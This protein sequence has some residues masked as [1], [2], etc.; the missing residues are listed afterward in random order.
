MRRL[1]PLPVLFAALSL[2]LAACQTDS[3]TVTKPAVKARSV[4]HET[5]LGRDGVR[6]TIPG[7]Y[8]GRFEENQYFDRVFSCEEH[9]VSLMYCVN[10]GELVPDEQSMAYAV[11]RNFELEYPSSDILRQPQTTENGLTWDHYVCVSKGNAG[12]A[13]INVDITCNSGRL[14]ALI[15]LTRLTSP[16]DK[17]DWGAG[18]MYSYITLMSPD[19]KANVRESEI[20]SR[21]KNAADILAFIGRSYLDRNRNAE[22]IP[23][24]KAAREVRPNDA[25]LAEFLAD[26]RLSA[27]Q[28]EDVLTEANAMALRFPKSGGLVWRKAFALGEL[29][30]KDEALA[31]F[32]RAIFELGDHSTASLSA[33]FSYLCK[34]DEIGKH[35]DEVEGLANQNGDLGI[36]TYLARACI[37]SGDSERADK[38]LDDLVRR[39]GDN[40]QLAQ[41]IVWLYAD[42]GKYDKAHA[43]A[44]SFSDRGNP[45]GDYLEG[46]VYFREGKYTEARTAVM[47]SKEKLAN[48]R[49]VIELMDAINARLGKADTTLFQTKVEPVAL[50]DNF[51]SLL[52]SIPENYEEG[53]GAHRD[54][55]GVMYAFD[56]G[57]SLRTTHYARYHVSTLGA[58]SRMNEISMPFDPL[59]ERVFVNYLRVLDEKGEKIAEGELANYYVTNS[60]D[61]IVM[62]QKK[63]LRMPVPSLRP[64]CTVE[65]AVTYETLG[66]PERMQFQLRK[67]ASD[68][69]TRLA[70]AG[71]RGKTEAVTTM[72]AN[73]AETLPDTP[74]MRFFFAKNPDP[75]TTYS[76][77]PPDISFVPCAWFGAA[78][79]TWSD[80]CGEFVKS[81]GTLL[82][83]SPVAAARVKSLLGDTYTQDEAVK[84]ISA[85]VRDSLT[86]QG[87]LFGVRAMVPNTC[88][89]ILSNRYGDCKDHSYLLMQMLNAAGVKAHLALV[90][91]NRNVN[92][93]MPDTFQFNHMIVYLPE[94]RGGIFLDMTDKGVTDAYEP[95]ALV[96]CPCLIIDPANPRIVNVPENP[97]QSS[98]LRITRDITLSADGS[99]TVQEEAVM[100]GLWAGYIRSILRGR[101]PCEYSV[102]LSQSTRI[103]GL[104]PA[105]TIEAENLNDLDK[106]VVL[107]Y[108]FSV[109]NFTATGKSLLGS[110]PST[111]DEDQLL[112]PGDQPVRRV[113]IEQSYAL[114]TSV[115]I[116]V[117]LPEGYV[118][119][120]DAVGSAVS[121]ETPY[122]LFKMNG[123]APDAR[124]LHYSVFLSRKTGLFPAA[125]SLEREKTYSDALRALH[126]PIELVKAADGS[127]NQH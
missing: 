116:R 24:I 15:S 110:L 29:D 79:R 13:R 74:G 32:H 14:V 38:V 28:Y 1:Y 22:A 64:G 50:P 76:A 19:P 69:P 5:V 42:A 114:D 25:A 94:Y 56:T 71:L 37:A 4:A 33:Y 11:M 118:L 49:N 68:I 61:E 67:L 92:T 97:P 39:A 27:H 99:A 115:E 58:I 40:V 113:P 70:F 6:W 87:L 103:S 83:P 60:T 62:S 45:I 101:S 65:Y 55:V 44:K 125:E 91:T 127:Q 7:T 122:L 81:V 30:R 23:F 66:K 59:Y 90:D 51:D 20:L 112:L 73:G 54:Y 78:G 16:T 35:L 89:T 84:K 2:F 120:A 31:E 107:R 95:F 46:A 18:T 8:S 82:E 77:M 111:W 26:A 119:G 121:A 105:H 21:R 43:L 12:Y 63:E 52:P 98:L 9:G 88:E 34:I 85:F 124:T 96:G 93:S 109:P 72:T 106:P 117:T 104:F 3:P 126:R 48:D 80:E 108:R 41:A 17:A 100:S 57:K 47:K 102:V 10:V 75:L 86:Y 36:Q 53:F 123:D